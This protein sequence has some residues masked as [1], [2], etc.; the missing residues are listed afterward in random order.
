M[1]ALG[2]YDLTLWAT[3]LLLLIYPPED[4]LISTLSRALALSVLV[5]P[6]RLLHRPE[7]WLVATT[8]AVLGVLYDWH[9]A[10]NHKYLLAY[11]LLA[12]FCTMHTPSPER[13][14]ASSARYLIIG[15]MGWAV[16]HKVSS[17][18]YLSGE[19]FTHAILLDE[20]FESV[21]KTLA[22][23]S[24]E[25]LEDNRVAV[26][27]LTHW[28]LKTNAVSIAGAPALAGIACFVTWFGVLFEAAIALMFLF[29]PTFRL[30]GTVR[31]WLLLGFVGMVYPI[32]S[33]LGFA[34][35][36]VAMGLAQSQGKR[37]TWAYVVCL[38]LLQLF[39]YHWSSAL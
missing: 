17:P 31:D 11:W 27:H 26:E 22:G 29:P 9:S 36:L 28:S 34:Y 13:A 6:Q 16:Y 35:T 32:A 4:A 38:P 33:V 1:A 5:F 24:K 21:A 2:K 3:V 19:F 8:L 23:I 14:L 10:D 30:L 12:I 39:G 15:T 18:D 37:A 7:V 25:V 20:R